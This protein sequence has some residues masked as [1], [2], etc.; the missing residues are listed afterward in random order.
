MKNSK[1][2]RSLSLLNPE[3]LHRFQSFVSSGYMNK[4]KACVDLLEH[5]MAYYPDLGH[6]HLVKERVFSKIYPDETFSSSR[7]NK[8]NHKLFTLFEH[9]VQCEINSDMKFRPELDLLAYY[10]DQGWSKHFQY[11]KNQLEK[12]FSESVELIDETLHDKYRYEFE[13]ASYETEF[14]IRKSGIDMETYS[15]SLD[16][17]YFVSKIEHYCGM[18]SMRLVLGKEFDDSGLPVLKRLITNSGL[19]EEPILKIWYNVMVLL[20]DR[21]NESAL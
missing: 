1:I 17:Y 20:E 11:K 10:N 3:K 13:V 9:F 8:L 2:I 19:V 15:R 16:L 6:R 18:L 7:I 12:Q 5:L 21:D 4:D 14:G